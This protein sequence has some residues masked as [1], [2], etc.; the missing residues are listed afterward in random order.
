MKITLKMIAL[1]MLLGLGTQAGAGIIHQPDWLRQ[2]QGNWDWLP[3]PGAKPAPL[4]LPEDFSLVWNGVSVPHGA[5]GFWKRFPIRKLHPS[6]PELNPPTRPTTRV[7]EPSTI[8]LMGLGFAMLV[9]VRLRLA[10]TGRLPDG[11]A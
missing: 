9:L 11:T 8:E 1:M 6:P 2:P 3:V 5:D 4:H 10:R 7:W